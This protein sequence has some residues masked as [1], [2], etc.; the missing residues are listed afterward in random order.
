MAYVRTHHLVQFY[1][2]FTC[3][4]TCPS[5]PSSCL[6]AQCIKSSAGDI[7]N[8]QTIILI[9][10]GVICSALTAGFI[11]WITLRITSQRYNLYS[12][13]LVVPRGLLR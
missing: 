13:F 8:T 10:E 2:T 1:C 6:H 5:L 9:I 4:T 7:N 12:V 3:A 11:I